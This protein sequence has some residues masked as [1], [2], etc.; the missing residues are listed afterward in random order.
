MKHCK[1]IFML[2]PMVVLV[3][4]LLTS[5]ALRQKNCQ[6]GKGSNILL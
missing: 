4:L 2:V 5:A 6:Y 1:K 3:G